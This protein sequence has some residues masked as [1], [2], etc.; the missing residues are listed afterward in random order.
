MDAIVQWVKSIAYYFIFVQFILYFMPNGKYES[1]VKLFSGIVFLLLLLCPLTGKLDLNG[2]LAYAYEKILFKQGT[3]EFEQ[4]LWGMEEE[5][6]KQ[7][8]EQYEESIASD[9]AVLAEAEGFVCI[10]ANAEIENRSEKE[11]FGQVIRLELV[12]GREKTSEKEEWTKI[13]EIQIR[14]QQTEQEEQEE[15]NGFQKKLAKYYGLEETDIHIV[16]QDD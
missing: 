16:W 10:S 12:L 14:V 15:E 7:V 11:K 13:E 2:K 1:Y 6:I 4:R 8:L 9:V 5:R 3:G